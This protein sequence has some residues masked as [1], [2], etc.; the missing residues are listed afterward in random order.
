MA[1][2]VLVVDDSAFMRKIISDI[3]NEDSDID[4]VGT[5][6]NGMD[7]LE[8]IKTLKPDV[9]TL[10]VEMPVMD[11][12]ETLK[13]IM[14]EH[15]I[16]VVMLS[17][18]TVE[19]AES[20]IKALEL[21]AIDFITKPTSIFDMDSSK[22]RYELTNKIK[23]AAVAKIST[24]ILT[25]NPLK[26]LEK[27]NSKK[28]QRK[29]LISKISKRNNDN[30]SNIIAIGTSTGGPRALQG[31]IPYFTQDINGSI[32]VVQHMPPGFTQSLANR[33]DSMSHISVKEAENGEKIQ[34]GWCYIAPGDYHM[35][36]EDRGGVFY[37]KLT[38]AEPVSGHRPSVD[39]LMDS[40][41]RINRIP[42]YGV[43]LT[44][45]GGDGAKGMKKIMDN[46][47]YTI[48]QDEETCVIYGMPKVAVNLGAIKEILPL[49]KIA[50]H[51]NEKVG[52]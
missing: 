50:G 3:L 6:R 28:T 30:V 35:E 36:I 9:V 48:A 37:I 7:A 8:K 49:D 18:I 27:T 40:A 5:G 26:P 23:A 42:I 52:V 22:K 12:L 46:N 47:G 51:L 34:K 16:S 17:S 19:G 43:I 1:I 14:S 45:M 38:E 31:I 41:A 13:Q 32:L 10:D 25:K 29:S 24:N 2:K 11:G 21:G 39:V 44:G 33:L 4:V 15:K 20:T